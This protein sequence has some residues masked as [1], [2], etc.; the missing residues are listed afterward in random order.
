MKRKNDRKFV[1][2]NDTVCYGPATFNDIGYN[3]YCTWTKTTKH[4]HGNPQIYTQKNT[5][6]KIL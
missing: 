6:N 4:Q 5:T 2:Y 1:N 3:N